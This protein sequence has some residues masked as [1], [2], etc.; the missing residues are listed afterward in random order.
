MADSNEE[1]LRRSLDAV[2]RYRRRLLIGL[3]LMFAGLLWAFYDATDVAR[4]GTLYFI[5]AIFVILL[6]WTALLAL[7]VVIQITVMTKRILRAIELASR[8]RPS[9]AGVRRPSKPSEIA[10]IVPQQ[11]GDRA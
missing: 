9:E 11:A 5:H 2:D 3:A 10:R 4:S 8:K 6:I 7:V 1:I